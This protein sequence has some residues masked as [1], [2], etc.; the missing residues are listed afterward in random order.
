M[1]NDLGG[2]VMTLIS[3]KP[4][5]RALLLGLPLRGVPLLPLLGGRPPLLLLLPGMSP[6]PAL[7]ICRLCSSLQ[8][9]LLLA[10]QAL[11][12]L[13]LMLG[14]LQGARRRLGRVLQPVVPAHTSY[15]DQP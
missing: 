1:P 9:R 2:G 8:M 3:N 13:L 12:T 15:I 5:L 7:I 10:S 14:G 6:A 11:L 4:G